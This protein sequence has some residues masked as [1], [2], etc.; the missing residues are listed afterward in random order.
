MKHVIPRNECQGENDVKTMI[1]INQRRRVENQTRSVVVIRDTMIQDIN[2][3][4]RL[5]DSGRE[6]RRSR[7]VF[8]GSTVEWHDIWLSQVKHLRVTGIEISRDRNLGL[9]KGKKSNS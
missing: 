7:P 9:M 4:R 5:H 3:T 2:H 1:M 8:P 6:K